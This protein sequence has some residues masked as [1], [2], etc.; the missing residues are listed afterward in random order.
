MDAVVLRGRRPAPDHPR[1]AHRRSKEDGSGADPLDG[2][3]VVTH[4]DDRSALFGDV[5]DPVQAPL[6]ELVVADGEHL[7]DEQDLWL[8]VGGDAEREPHRHPRGVP[9]DRGVDELGGICEVDDLV[10][11]RRALPFVFMPR[12]APLRMTFSRPVSSGWNPVP[13]SRSDPTRP[14]MSARSLEG[15]VMRAMIFSI[16]VLPAPLRPISPSG[17]SLAQLN[18]MSL[19]AQ[20]RY[21]GSSRRFFPTKRAA[22]AASVSLRV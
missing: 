3:H 4:E 14:R 21:R 13:T 22:P 10:E 20:N 16:V 6:L 19:S 18:E 11:L 17:L 8:E 2:A 1:R 5:D 7:V 12:T 9:L 15:R